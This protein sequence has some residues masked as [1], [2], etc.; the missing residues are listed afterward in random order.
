MM[1]VFEGNMKGQGQQRR[2]KEEEEEARSVRNIAEIEQDLIVRVKVQ[3][4]VLG[5][6]HH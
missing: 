2:R 1:E 6:H 5:K 3:N 4:R